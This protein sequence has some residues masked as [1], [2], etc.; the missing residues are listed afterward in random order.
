MSAVGTRGGPICI[1][2]WAFTYT[3][4]PDT[5]P[6]TSSSSSHLLALKAQSI[7]YTHGGLCLTHSWSFSIHIN[8]NTIPI[9]ILKHQH[10]LFI[11]KVV[12]LRADIKKQTSSHDKADFC[13]TLSYPALSQDRCIVYLDV[14]YNRLSNIDYR[15]L[16]EDKEDILIKERR[17]ESC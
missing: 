2:P 17:P 4:F 1:L 12:D 8:D 5:L 10:N 6:C 9:S 7:T 3:M 11:I 16:L 14:Y 15:G 13:L